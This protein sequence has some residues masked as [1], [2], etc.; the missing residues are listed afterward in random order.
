MK[1]LKHNKKKV[2]KIDV[3]KLLTNVKKLSRIKVSKIIVMFEL[4]IN[5]EEV[6]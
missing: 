2:N 1:L 4:I 3:K 6:L 5:Q